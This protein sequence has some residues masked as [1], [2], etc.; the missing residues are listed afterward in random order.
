MWTKWTDEQKEWLA[1]N[2]GH[3]SLEE[4]VA[5]FNSY[6]GMDRTFH[7][8][9][10]KMKSLGIRYNDSKQIANGL[11]GQN[12]DW[13]DEWIVSNFDNYSTAK[14]M[15]DAYNKEFNT[16]INSSSLRHHCK[17]K[18]GL[19]RDKRF[20]EEQLE[21]LKQN[22][23]YQPIKETTNLFNAYFND[24]KSEGGIVGVAKRL[25]LHVTK[26]IRAKAGSNNAPKNLGIGSLR[27]QGGCKYLYIK[28]SNDIGAEN[29]KLLHH[30][31]YEQHYGPIPENHVVIFLDNNKYNCSIDNLKAIPRHWIGVLNGHKLK[32]DNPEITK[33]ALL[34]CEIR[35]ELIS[36]NDSVYTFAR[37]MK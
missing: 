34:W 27:V 28:V 3:F 23:P 5:E 9:K 16:S 36:K 18:L 14:E 2:A 35:D 4:V 19:R 31:V 1:E 30:H 15:T 22:Y 37:E 20:S 11:R 17:K 8:V 33:S 7:S 26:E 10:D 6:F 21:W 25:G 29:W 24:N 32:S 13:N 12:I